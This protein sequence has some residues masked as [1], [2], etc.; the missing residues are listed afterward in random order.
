VEVVSDGIAKTLLMSRVPRTGLLATNGH[1]RGY[2]GLRAEGRVAR[3]EVEPD[4]HESAA[5]LQKMAL[6]VAR[7]YGRDWYLVVRK[8]QEPSVLSEIPGTSN[9]FGEDGVALPP[10]VEVVRVHA[11][12]QEEVVRGA[13]FAGVERW[14]LRDLVAAGPQVDGSYLAPIYGNEWWMLTPTEGLPTWI[15][16]PTVLV[17]E[18]ELVPSPGDPQDTPVVPPPPL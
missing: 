2:L 13:A 16:A 1:A 18:A 14:M 7:S 5:K 10:P 6:K 8:L 11:D 17:E 12:G 4:H 15:S 9:P 3:L